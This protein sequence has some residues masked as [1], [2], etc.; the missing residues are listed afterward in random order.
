MNIPNGDAL[1]LD[2][3]SIM[4]VI[5]SALKYGEEQTKAFFTSQGQGADRYLAHNLVRFFAKQYFESAGKPVNDLDET[6][7]E[8]ARLGNNGLQLETEKYC[9]RIR[10]AV[11]G[12]LPAAGS[13][14]L[15]QFYDQR[16]LQ[17]AGVPEPELLKLVVL[18]DVTP[19]Y[20]LTSLAL[21]LPRYGGN[22]SEPEV[23]W[24]VPIAMDEMLN[25]PSA[26]D[27]AGEVAGDDDDF[28]MTAKDDGSPKKQESDSENDD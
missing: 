20:S 7:Y 27:D 4:D 1:L 5:C 26:Q 11:R 12:Q 6:D 14:M 28:P 3:Q 15:D 9:I 22:G 8:L 24:S 13:R 23:Y 10:K 18:W 21:A 16:M 19:D 17:F 2:A 25:P